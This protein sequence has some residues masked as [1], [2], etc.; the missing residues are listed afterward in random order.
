MLLGAVSWCPL[1]GTAKAGGCAAESSTFL[2][3][4]GLFCGWQRV[5]VEVCLEGQL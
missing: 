3:A 1:L 5:S 2:L 4:A